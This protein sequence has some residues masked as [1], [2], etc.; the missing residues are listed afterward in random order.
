MPGGFAPRFFVEAGFLILLGVGAGYADLRP[1]VIVGLLAAGWA[2]VSLVELAVW[3]SEA[4]PVAA[5]VPPAAPAEEEEVVE[6][7]EEEPAAELPLEETDY[8]LRAGAGEEPSAEVEEYT[9]VLARPEGDRQDE[10]A[11]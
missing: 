5:Y 9:R 7:V 3:R 6:V 4:R 8:P 11:Q 2:V 10:D 1:I